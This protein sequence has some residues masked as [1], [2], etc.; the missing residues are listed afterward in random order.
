MARDNIWTNSDGLAVG[1]GTR[2]IASTVSVKHPGPDG[3]LEQVVLRIR[4]EDLADVVAV[5]EDQVIH[6]VTIPNGAVIV[7][8]ET[9]VLED[10]VGA[11]AVL[12]IG[13]YDNA[14]T[15][16]DDDGID[17]AIA[18]ATLVVSNGPIAADGADISTVVATTGGVKI[19]AS[20]DTAP[21]TAGE[22]VCT[23][24]YQVPPA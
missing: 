5:S 12:D 1:F 24:K 8:A 3:A 15:I 23:I 16:V 21:F 6:G 11:T 22:A 2:T 10:F 20:Y 9:V 18:V 17:A 13:V 7:S 14:G 4:G 19:C